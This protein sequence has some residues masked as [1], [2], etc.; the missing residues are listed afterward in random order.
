MTC[1]RIWEA[2]AARDGRLDAE[3]RLRHV[4]HCESCADCRR[5]IARL[6]T[7]STVLLDL[8]LAPRDDM[9][10]R[11]WRGRLLSEVGAPSARS[12]P[13]LLWL[14]PLVLALVLVAV[15]LRRSPQPPASASP[16]TARV[17]AQGEARWTRSLEGDVDRVT[18]TEGT[19]TVAVG[20]PKRARLLVVLPD[21]TLEDIGTRFVVTVRNGRTTH[22][23]VDEGAVVLRLVGQPERMLEAGARWN[24][25]A[26]PVG[27]PA[28][29]DTPALVTSASTS[30]LT[31]KPLPMAS[32]KAA[33][34]PPTAGAASAASLSGDVAWKEALVAFREGEA[35]EAYRRFTSFVTAF[36]AH[37]KAEDA[38]YL[39]IVAARRGGDAK[40]AKVAA[41]DY[42]SRFPKG[43]RRIEAE[44][45]RDT[46]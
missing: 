32:V 38:A 22:V 25:P 35:I 7:V 8:P 2:E 41:G 37:A 44:A 43:F 11:R 5:E 27:S 30:T 20:A 33:I 26:A 31:T 28:S 34:Q 45:V 39:R 14:A 17:E 10:A 3:D 24:A 12:V 4:R 16:V 13:P 1:P 36:P 9:S 42:L 15:G 6:L 29:V 19:L 21:G 23:A 40:A 46:P 18:L